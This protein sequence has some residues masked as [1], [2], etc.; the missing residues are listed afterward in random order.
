MVSVGLSSRHHRLTGPTQPHGRW[1]SSVPVARGARFDTGARHPQ[2]GVVSGERSSCPGYRKPAL[3][4]DPSSASPNRY[5]ADPLCRT[6]RG[7]RD[8]QR[9]VTAPSSDAVSAI[10]L[11]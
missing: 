11:V 8:P 2:R 1:E 5:A 10:S 9:H 6:A 3:R 4:V 7:R